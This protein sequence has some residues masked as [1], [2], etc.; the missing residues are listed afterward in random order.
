MIKFVIIKH[1][2][3]SVSI[4]FF[5]ILLKNNSI[6]VSGMFYPWPDSLIPIFDLLIIIETNKE[7]S[8]NKK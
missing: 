5:K 6:I 3:K 4:C 2:L 7:I 1:I 8:Y